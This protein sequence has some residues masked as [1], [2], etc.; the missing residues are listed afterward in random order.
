MKLEPIPQLAK[1]VVARLRL[2][3]A[4]A[5]AGILFASGPA[6]AQAEASTEADQHFQQAVELMKADNCTEAV[7]AFLLSQ[8]LDPSAATLLN[9]ATCQARLGRS[10]TAYK[11]YQ[12]AAEL[13]ATE[14]NEPLRERALQA[15]SILG[16]ALTRLQI[17]SNSSARFSIRVNGEELDDYAGLP[18]PLDPGENVIE[19][20]AP[21]REPWRKS[22]TASDLGAT[23]VI[24]V[25]DLRPV[26]PPAPPPHS[27]PMPLS[28]STHADTE[29]PFDRRL[30]AAILGGAGLASILAGAV[31]AVSANNNYDD[32]GP[33]CRTNR[34]TQP[35]I[36]LRDRAYDKATVSTVT[37]S[38]GLVAVAAGVVL[39]LTAPDATPARSRRATSRMPKAM[40]DGDGF[41]LRVEAAR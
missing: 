18:I 26:A 7:P 31:F 12:Q 3:R 4:A 15:M 34:C 5:V 21:G 10:G 9:I 40:L 24:E 39:W 38:V 20:A 14:K 25:P 32:A 1:P 11:T 13:A 17:I 22:V 23:I 2:A 30:P 33:Y 19:A 27:A 16:P 35:G 37:I 41:G 6:H 36:D 28:P 29:R 8:K